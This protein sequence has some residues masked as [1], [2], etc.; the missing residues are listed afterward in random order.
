MLRWKLRL[1]RRKRRNPI[2][3]RNQRQVKAA[4]SFYLLRYRRRLKALRLD[5]KSLLRQAQWLMFVQ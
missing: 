3:I 1:R 2:T 5:E 4:L